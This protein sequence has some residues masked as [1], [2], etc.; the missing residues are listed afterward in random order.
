IKIDAAAAEN[1]R[2]RQSA[3]TKPDE[4]LSS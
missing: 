1:I 3:G 4:P 2:A